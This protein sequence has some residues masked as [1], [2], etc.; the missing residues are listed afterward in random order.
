GRLAD[1]LRPRAV[2][3]VLFLLASGACMSVPLLNDRVNDKIEWS[4]KSNEAS[5]LVSTVN[6]FSGGKIPEKEE[7]K[8]LVP[9]SGRVF[10]HVLLVFLLPS[11][12]L[13]TIGPV[14]AKM[15]L[16]RSKRIGRTVGNVYAWGALGSIVGTF[17]TGFYL[18]SK[19]GTEAVVWSV[20]GALGVMGLLFCLSLLWSASRPSEALIPFFAVFW[21]LGIPVLVFLA[22]LNHWGVFK[23][24]EWPWQWVERDGRWVLRERPA[25]GR[26]IVYL[27]ESDYSFIKVEL[28]T[29]EDEDGGEGEP[30]KEVRRELVLDNLIHAYYVPGKIEKLEYDYEGIYKAVTHRYAP[31]EARE[32]EGLKALFIGGGGYIYPRYL[33]SVWPECYIEIAEIDP[34]VTRAVLAEFGLEKDSVQIVNS[35]ADRSRKDNPIW[36]H[37]LDA[38]NHIEDLVRRKDAG[39]PVPEFDFI[40]GDAFNDYTV[41]FHL[42]TEEFN[43]KVK[44]LLKP[45]TGVY[46]INIIDIFN[47]GSFLGAIYN[48]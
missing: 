6:S 37:H 27:D 7:E 24:G 19:L 2:L 10:A 36:I 25:A 17:V 43:Q 1:W 41:P 44:R 15:A 33:R 48:T 22:G 11:T 46:M 18:T 14:V 21:A 39:E 28:L 5:W 32:R 45:G 30:K 12:I 47:P 34:A 16:E 4:P 9:W 3:A 23:G 40:Y 8:L 35:L 26:D 31:P 38:R 29:E 20:G 13:G 42:T